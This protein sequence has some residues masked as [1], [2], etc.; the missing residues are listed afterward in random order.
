MTYMRANNI[1]NYS[2]ACL[3]VQSMNGY[4]VQQQPASKRKI[5]PFNTQLM[6]M[7]MMIIWFFV[8]FKILFRYFCLKFFLF[9]YNLTTAELKRNFKIFCS[10]PY[11]F[12]LKKMN[13]KVSSL[14]NQQFIDD[15]EKKD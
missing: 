3:Y 1:F 7:S 5:N 12:F 4:F 2:F 8:S 15:D 9:H 14:I 10:E 6:I 11:N 13:P